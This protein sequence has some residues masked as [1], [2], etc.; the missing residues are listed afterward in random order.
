L[1]NIVLTDKTHQQDPT[2][3]EPIGI[4]ELDG[5]NIHPW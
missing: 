4:D 1:K 3:T 2:T 5:A